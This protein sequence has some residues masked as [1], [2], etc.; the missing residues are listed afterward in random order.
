MCRPM[1]KKPDPAIIP[2]QSK[3]FANGIRVGDACKLAGINPAT[4]S[5]WAAGGV[6]D[7]A[8]LRD[9]ERTVDEIVT[10]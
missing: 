10:Q 7:L 3:M 2:V 9:L 5:R 8:K 4:W 6:P 1:S